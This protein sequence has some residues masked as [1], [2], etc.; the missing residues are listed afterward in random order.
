MVPGTAAAISASR[1]GTAS[2]SGAASRCAPIAAQASSRGI[3]SGGRLTSRPKRAKASLE[4]AH[5]GGD[6]SEVRPANPSSGQCHHS[7]SGSPST[8]HSQ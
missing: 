2:A 5:A 8:Q 3:A 6:S 4:I 1:S 7:T